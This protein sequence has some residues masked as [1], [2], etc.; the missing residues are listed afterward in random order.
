MSKVA[1]LEN[2][3][4]RW[5]DLQCKRYDN[6]RGIR[7]TKFYPKHLINFNSNL[8]LYGLKG[9]SWEYDEIS[10]SWDHILS[11]GVISSSLGD[12]TLTKLGS[13]DYRCFDY[14]YRSFPSH[15]TDWPGRTTI[16]GG[17]E[18]KIEYRERTQWYNARI[19]NIRVTQHPKNIYYTAWEIG[20]AQNHNNSVEMQFKILDSYDLHSISN[21]ENFYIPGFSYKLFKKGNEGLTLATRTPHGSN[22]YLQY[23]GGSQFE[24]ANWHHIPYFENVT[25]ASKI[26]GTDHWYQVELEI[27]SDQITS[28]TMFIMISPIWITTNGF[29]S[30]NPGNMQFASLSKIIYYDNSNEKLRI[31]CGSFTDLPSGI[32]QPADWNAEVDRSTRFI[33]KLNET[34]YGI[35]EVH[36]LKK[37][38]KMEPSWH[39]LSP[40]WVLEKEVS[41]SYT[42]VKGVENFTGTLGPQKYRHIRVALNS[43]PED[44]LLA[45]DDRIAAAILPQDDIIQKET[46]W[47]ITSASGEMLGFG[48]EGITGFSSAGTVA[49]ALPGALFGFKD[50]ITNLDKA[51]NAENGLL[52]QYYQEKAIAGL[53]SMG[54]SFVPYFGAFELAWKIVIYY[55]ASKYNFDIGK[56]KLSTLASPPD[57]VAFALAYLTPVLIPYE[58]CEMPYLDATDKVQNRVDYKNLWRDEGDRYNVYVPPGI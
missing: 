40:H 30:L 54:L 26:R 17:H 43:A 15:L 58:L 22:E 12:D 6:E 41:L 24:Y 34:H 29:E 33:Q 2:I 20:L 1:P 45:T 19:W 18:Y 32:S 31:G 3:D 36:L 28:D 5:T 9:S 56:A 16:D 39:I 11:P 44:I 50:L 10:S 25:A 55:I 52:R 27:P 53:F 49:G 37:A 4:T 13:G 38:K 8:N 23:P 47:A 42:E 35:T 21:E 51:M 7:W 57:L 14:T 46:E 48:V